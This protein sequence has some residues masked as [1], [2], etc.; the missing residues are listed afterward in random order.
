MRSKCKARFLAG[1]GPRLAGSLAGI[2]LLVMLLVTSSA[3]AQTTPRPF[4]QTSH[5]IIPDLPADVLANATPEEKQCFDSVQDKIAWNAAGST[6]WW[7]Y[8]VWDLCKG[9][10]YPTHLLTCFQNEM[11]QQDDFKLA[12]MACKNAEA[13]LR[14]GQPAGTKGPPPAAC[15]VG[16]P[17]PTIVSPQDYQACLIYYAVGPTPA[18]PPDPPSKADNGTLPSLNAQ[19]QSCHD[20][21]QDHVTGNS[22][23]GTHWLESDLRVLCTGTPNGAWTV[24]CYRQ[25][26]QQ[27]NGYFEGSVSA[28]KKSTRDSLQLPIPA[29]DASASSLGITR[30]ACSQIVGCLINTVQGFAPADVCAGCGTTALK[31]PALGTFSSLQTLVQSPSFYNACGT[32]NQIYWLVKAFNAEG[33][34]NTLVTSTICAVNPSSDGLCNAGCANNCIGKTDP[35][36]Y[37]RCV[38]LCGCGSAVQQA[39]SSLGPQLMGQ[40]I[41]NGLNIGN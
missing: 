16:I 24:T 13:A 6:H 5:G 12:T 36:A 14:P 7:E 9:T 23:G 29:P 22:S 8:N 17:N 1:M 3:F 33:A 20:M 15:P 27:T 39:C 31:S 32:A 19:E 28:C 4:P 40:M 21:L 18:I 38:E 25:V 10:K 41:C 34:I 2:A 35:Q 11:K 37:N 30:D 26:L